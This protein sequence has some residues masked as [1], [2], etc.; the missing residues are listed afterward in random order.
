MYVVARLQ[1][2]FVDRIRILFGWGIKIE[3]I[4]TWREHESKSW[5]HICATI[6]PPRCC[7]PPSQYT[8]GLTR[9]TIED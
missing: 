6:I 4:A 1:W 9:I 3:C 8:D 2:S 7:A 5:N